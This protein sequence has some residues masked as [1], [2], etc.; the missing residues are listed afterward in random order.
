VSQDIPQWSFH[1]VATATHVVAAVALVMLVL[2]PTRGM[3]LFC[4][5]P[6]VLSACA[7]VAARRNRAITLYIAFGVLVGFVF[8]SFVSAVNH[9]AFLEALVTALLA[10]G[11]AWLLQQPRWPAAAFTTVV[12]CLLGSLLVPMLYTSPFSIDPVYSRRSGVT[13]LSMLVIGLMYVGLGVWESAL[14][15]KTHDDDGRSREKRRAS[16]RVQ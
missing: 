9:G 8:W 6:G 16:E 12:A 11:A 15:R 4:I 1:I 5:V 10:V 2:A 14:N 3:A 7:A 13:G